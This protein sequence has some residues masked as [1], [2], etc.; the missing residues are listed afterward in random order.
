MK[1][2]DA[3]PW[4]NNYWV[5]GVWSWQDEHYHWPVQKGDGLIVAQQGNRRYRVVDVWYSNNHHGYFDDG[6]HIFLEEV[7]GTEDDRPGC[8]A[9]PDYFSS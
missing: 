5:H 1:V 2:E 8:S 3:L 9:P 4:I 6:R 7:T